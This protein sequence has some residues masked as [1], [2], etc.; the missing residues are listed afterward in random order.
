MAYSTVNESRKHCVFSLTFIHL[1]CI[2]LADEDF[3][4]AAGSSRRNMFTALVDWIN[5]L[6]WTR[7]AEVEDDGQEVNLAAVFRL[8][9]VTDAK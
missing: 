4:C 5:Q 9:I 2:T 8:S 7:S 3:S 6:P 1:R